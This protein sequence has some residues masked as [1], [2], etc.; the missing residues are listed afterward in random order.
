MTSCKSIFISTCF[1]YL[2]TPYRKDE[3]FISLYFWQLPQLSPFCHDNHAFYCHLTL[4]S[5]FLV[6][7][8]KLFLFVY[9][10][11]SGHTLLY[12]RVCVCAIFGVRVE[13]D[14]MAIAIGKPPPEFVRGQTFAVAPRYSG[15]VYIGEG[16]YGM[17]WWV[18]GGVANII[19]WNFFQW[20]CTRS[21]YLH[22]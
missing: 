18:G 8:Y 5:C 10:L 13:I 3:I 16:A 19:L 17:V 14:E 1:Y 21:F 20:I 9:H 4:A 12:F 2:I 15:L 22:I 11:W 7:W 6:K